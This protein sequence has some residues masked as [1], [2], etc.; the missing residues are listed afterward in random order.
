MQAGV[1]ITDTI[2]SDKTTFLLLIVLFELMLKIFYMCVECIKFPD[3]RMA[4]EYPPAF[5]QSC[6]LSVQL[7]GSGESDSERCLLLSCSLKITVF[8]HQGTEYS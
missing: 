6:T 5:F 7:A 4:A 1:D 3:L 2:I 8:S